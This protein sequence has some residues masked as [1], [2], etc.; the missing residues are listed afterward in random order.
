MDKTES[1]NFLKLNESA[2]SQAPFSAANIFESIGNQPVKKGLDF[3][4]TKGLDL[5][6]AFKQG[7]TKAVV[8]EKSPE[9]PVA[10]STEN[11]AIAAA[12]KT[13]D[14]INAQR[15][16]DLNPGYIKLQEFFD[17]SSTQALKDKNGKL[18]FSALKTLNE[19]ARNEGRS[20]DLAVGS[21]VEKNFS[22]LAS[23]NRDSAI[24]SDRKISA[25][26]IKSI[27]TYDALLDV[28]TTPARLD[29]RYNRAYQ[30]GGALVG[31]ALG[32]ALQLGIE[33]VPGGKFIE[34]GGMALGNTLFSP[35]GAFAGYLAGKE[36]SLGITG[37]EK[38]L[39]HYPLTVGGVFAGGAIGLSLGSRAWGPT[40]GAA[41]G[42]YVV[43]AHGDKFLPS[44]AADN[45]KRFST[46]IS[47][48]K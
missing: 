26:D 39:L 36:M 40:L 14:D 13:L 48:I 10:A 7:A 19:K 15:L 38:S 32:T 11:Q 35:A 3:D 30:I 17:S 5:T 45:Y 47:K 4:P 23:L 2:S 28:G 21:F 33:H 24:L 18:D 42:V 46:E 16:K 25:S 9:K 6:D 43:S 27:P 22:E 1:V 8:Q 29:P 20:E 44:T 12:N 37:D 34:K 41:L 31:A